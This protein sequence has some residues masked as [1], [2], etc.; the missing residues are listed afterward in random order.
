MACIIP[1]FSM[2][3]NHLVMVWFGVQAGCI[4]ES[5]QIEEE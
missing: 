4:S 1:V 5:A 3:Y 2:H